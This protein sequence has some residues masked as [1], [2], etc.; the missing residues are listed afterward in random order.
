MIKL[1]IISEGKPALEIEA[2]SRFSLRQKLFTNNVWIR[3]GCAGNGSCG[4]CKVKILGKNVNEPTPNER[5][6]LG[7]NDISKGVRLACQVYLQD[8]LQIEIPKLALETKWYYLQRT[9]IFENDF[10]LNSDLLHL[11]EKQQDAYGLAIDLGTTTIR[12][13]IYNLKNGKFQ[14]GRFGYN[15]QLEVGDNVVT[16]LQHASESPELA[17]EMKDMVIQAIGDALLDISLKEGINIQQL[18]KVTVVG[19]TAMLALLT[20]ENYHLLLKSAYWSKPIE[21][22]LKEPKS[23]I[24]KLRINSQS[25]I[26]VIQ[27]ISGF[28]GSDFLAGIV[29]TD[30]TRSESVSLFI[31]FGTN[32]EIGLWD[33]EELWFTSAAGGPAF[34]GSGISCG[35]PAVSGAINTVKYNEDSQRFDIGTIDNKKIKGI[36]GSG[37]I[38][39]IAELN[40]INIL[41]ERGSFAKR[42]MN[43]RYTLIENDIEIFITKKDVDV[44]QRA[45]AAIG[46]GIRVLLSKNS[47]S[48]KEVK[49]IHIGGAFGQYINVNN[50]QQIGLLPIISKEGRIDFCGNTALL[51]CE[52]VLFSLK[53]RRE[54]KKIKKYAKLVNLAFSPLFDELYLENLFLRAL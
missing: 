36:C 53:L 40:K 7:K 41:T 39:L 45:K 10:Y 2:D 52:I 29:A 9:Q 32:S 44:F 13:S 8:D 24:N 18:F 31:D 34:E 16:R 38:D 11:I 50:A 4:L 30:L 27:P 51:G 5:I 23:M 46:A 1:T 21:C 43:N 19:N 15:P 49:R 3:S 17:Q 47:L 6:L 26:D 54:M 35:M 42:E 12:L 48:V 22:R 14:S 33:G 25:I 28:V 37:L 20:G